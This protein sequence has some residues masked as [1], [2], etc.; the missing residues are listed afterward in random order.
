MK[1]T[2]TNKKLLRK[3]QVGSPTGNNHYNNFIPAFNGFKGL[4]IKKTCIDNKSN[5]ENR[6]YYYQI[7]FDI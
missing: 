6:D 2:N 1:I 7:K 5:L 4:T 3:K